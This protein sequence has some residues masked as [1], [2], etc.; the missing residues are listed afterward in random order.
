MYAEKVERWSTDVPGRGASE[1]NTSDR[2]EER[3]GTIERCR[4]KSRA[5]TREGDRLMFREMHY[6]DRSF[7][8]MEL[9]E[10]MADRRRR[11][12]VATSKPS[13]RAR[14]LSAL[15][16]ATGSTQTEGRA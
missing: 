5:G 9:A 15:A 1:T 13:V 4:G 2:K 8:T 3:G 12:P 7:T 6:T 14:M 16:V 11:S 10:K